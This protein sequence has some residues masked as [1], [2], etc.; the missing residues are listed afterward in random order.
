MVYPWGIPATLGTFI[1]A[2][3]KQDEIGKQVPKEPGYLTSVIPVF[4]AVAIKR[5][6]YDPNY[7][8]YQSQSTGT[9]FRQKCVF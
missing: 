8:K 1:P 9:L 3:F 2:E 6:H 4:S 5:T 7:R